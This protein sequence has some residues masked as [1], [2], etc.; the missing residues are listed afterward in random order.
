MWVNVAK[1]NL[2]RYIIIC[3]AQLL[4][5]TYIVSSKIVVNEHF[6]LI[7]RKPLIIDLL[8]QDITLSFIQRSI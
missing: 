7:D 2:R 8:M 3:I 1:Y 4:S 6:L 5:A